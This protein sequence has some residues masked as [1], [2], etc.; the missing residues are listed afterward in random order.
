MKI[1]DD[2]LDEMAARAYQ[3]MP[4]RLVV[5][6]GTAALTSLLLPWRLCLVWVLFQI[7]CES[8]SVLVTRPQ[9]LGQKVSL[10]VRFAHLCTLVFGVSLW[11][12]LAVALWTTGTPAGAV[13]AVLIW[14]SV[15]FFAQNNAY[16]STT[17]FV[18]GGAIPGVAMLV[19]VIAGP[20]PLHLPLVPVCGLIVLSLSFVGDG[21]IRSLAVRRRFEEA[22]Q[23]LAASEGQYR[24]LA[25]NITDV[26]ALNQSDGRRLYLSPSV[27][28][29]LGYS[30]EELFDDN[31]R[32]IHPDD[33]AWVAEATSELAQRGGE[34]TL[35]LRMIH[36]Q[37]H[38][39]WMETNFAVVPGQDDQQQ[40]LLLSVARNIE[41]R[42]ALETELVEARER[43][44]EAAAAKANFLANMTHELRTPLNAIIGFSGVLAS[45]TRL[46]PADTRHANLI[47]DASNTLLELVDSVLDFSK[48]EAQAVELESKPFDPAEPARTVANLM[49]EQASARGLALSVRLEGEIRPLSGDPARLRQVL[50]NFVSNALKFTSEGGVTIVVRQSPAEAGP[51]ALRV[52]VRD[53]GIGIAKDQIERLFDRFTQADA[54]VS[55][56]YGGTG[57][58]LAICRHIVALMGGTTGCDSAPGQGATFWFELTLPRAGALTQAPK[59]VQPQGPERPLRML[60]VEDVGVNREL[61]TTLLSPFDIEIE[62]AENG[63]IAVDILSERSFDIVLMDV[64]MPVMDGL[65]A[66]RRIRALPLAHAKLTP[67]IAMTA[68]V[69]PDQVQ[70][71]LDAGMDDHLG[72]PIRPDALLAAL[73]KWSS[74]REAGGEAARQTA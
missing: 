54:T 21:V 29:A 26:I 28:R 40:P 19:F 23:K 74:G 55:R 5:T 11:M 24:L 39:V 59:Q 33:T 66:T 46:A 42:K 57:L 8:L 65:T 3:G 17:G 22:Q 38:P 18:V 20:N 12:G 44:E 61:I 4:L 10:R 35:Q 1:L 52:E 34:T 30:P 64:Q 50:M 6:A 56:R 62:T 51:D 49:A 32:V 15:V 13:S 27:H 58:G 36:K 37:G 48:L 60:L 43:A 31:F 70:S 14:L 72:K 9:A 25:D 7:L 69:L 45:S 68:N 63:Q 67:I 71:C 47:H 2:G 16:Q 73:S 41:A 53:T